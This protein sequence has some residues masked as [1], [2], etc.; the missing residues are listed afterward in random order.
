MMIPSYRYSHHHP[1]PFDLN[2]EHHLFTTTT[3]PQLSS[4]SSSLSSY[5]YW[6]Q[7]PNH[8]QITHQQAEKIHVPSS[9]G[10]WDHIHDHR[11]KEEKEEEEE[12]DG[13][14]KSS[15]LLK[16]KI[17]KKEERNE[18]HHLDN[19]AH[20]DEED[21]GSVKWMSSKMRIMGGS[22]TNNF[23]LRFDE[24]GPKQQA[25]LSPLGTDNSSSN[26]NNNNSSSNRHE[27]NNNMIVRVCSDCHTTKTPLW[28]SGPR[29]PKS[30]CNACG[31]RQRKARRAAAVAAAAE[32]AASE[33][34]T[35]LMASTDDDDGM[36]KKEKKL[37]KHNNKDKKLKAKCSA[38]NQLKKK[39]KI[40]TNNN[41]NTNKLSHRGRKKV[42]FEDLTI[43]LS[44]NL[45]LNVFPHDE[46]EAAILLMALSYGL[47]HGFPSDRYLD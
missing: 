31:I 19:Q 18:N 24:E 1:I 41:N 37:H 39:H 8:L 22:D 15:K 40:G 20:H 21:H 27:N 26:S 47:L 10:S 9:G 16:L 4:P 23:R 45:A 42:G 13:N 38:P 29:G 11:K 14:K 43:S 28:R 25:P 33:N 2:E 6:D 3:Y 46:K 30:L 12:E 36:K 17:L 7:H 32:V 44:K 35:T 34:D 5:S